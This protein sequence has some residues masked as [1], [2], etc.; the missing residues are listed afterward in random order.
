[1]GDSIAANIL[2]SKRIPAGGSRR[3]QK[4]LR[5]IPT[6]RSYV[7]KR[8]GKAN[9]IAAMRERLSTGRASVPPARRRGVLALARVANKLHKIVAGIGR[10]AEHPRQDI[11]GLRRQ[12]VGGAAFLTCRMHDRRQPVAACSRG[13]L[14]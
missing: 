7:A 3:A 6:T 2:R 1:M 9:L 14:A 13:R 11:A 8:S 5:T 4:A 12:H 10:A